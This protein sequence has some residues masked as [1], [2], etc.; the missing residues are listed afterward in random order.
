VSD[1]VVTRGHVSN[2]RGGLLTS[3]LEEVKQEL[4]GGRSFEGDED[5]DDLATIQAALTTDQDTLTIEAA[6]VA[7]ARGVEKECPV[8]GSLPVPR[9][10]FAPEALIACLTAWGRNAILSIQFLAW[11]SD[12]IRHTTTRGYLSL[13]CFKTETKP[14]DCAAPEAREPAAELVTSHWLHWDNISTHEGRLTQLDKDEGIV[15]RLMLC[16][17]DVVMLLLLSACNPYPIQNHNP[18]VP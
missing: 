17:C 5:A 15:Y 2:S 3:A 14:D 18:L 1:P 16:C 12:P 4:T 8:A 10:Q 13:V 11:S 7:K 9:L 6:L